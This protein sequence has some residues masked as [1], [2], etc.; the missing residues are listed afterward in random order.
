MGAGK[1][2]SSRGHMEQI[3]LVALFF[4]MDYTQQFILIRMSHMQIPASDVDTLCYK[5]HHCLS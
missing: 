1:Q 2:P 3:L 5:I 4:M